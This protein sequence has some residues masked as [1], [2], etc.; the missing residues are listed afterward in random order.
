MGGCGYGG[1]KGIFAYGA[2][3]A[4]TAVSNLVSSSGAVGTDVTGV[5][6]ART[7]V[8]ACGIGV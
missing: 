5:G 2:P 4:Y 6:T 7:G 8:S 3:G 1:D